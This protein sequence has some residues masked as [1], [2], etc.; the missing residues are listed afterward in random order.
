[1]PDPTL[2]RR[3]AFVTFLDA[4]NQVGAALGYVGVGGG[5][6]LA[7][8]YRSFSDRIVEA[9]KKADA[10]QRTADA[11]QKSADAAQRFADETKRAT[12]ALRG[13]DMGPASTL[14]ITHVQRATQ[15]FYEANVQP[16]LRRLI[17]TLLQEFYD[18]TIK[19]GL[20]T[21]WRSWLDDAK[22]EMEAERK[23]ALR[24]SRPDG[25]DP[26]VEQRINNLDRRLD[27][28]EHLFQE[29]AAERT[30]SWK[31]FHELVGEMRAVLR[32]R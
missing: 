12:E 8:I 6:I 3:I 24:S 10:A 32:N 25:V 22:E 21:A 2:S 31:K 5:G 28:L 1:L 14:T 18:S 7:R 16:S 11:A 4:M 19:G 20:K 27:Q 26:F 9:E 29:S 13:H 15:E 30:E 23:R 17:Q